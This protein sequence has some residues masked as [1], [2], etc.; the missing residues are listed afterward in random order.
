MCR[1]A[2]HVFGKRAAF[3]VDSVVG[4]LKDILKDSFHCS[5]FFLFL[6]FPFLS[7]FFFFFSSLTLETLFLFFCFWFYN[8]I[9]RLV[10]VVAQYLLLCFGGT[11]FRT[12][13]PEDIPFREPPAAI[14]RGKSAPICCF[15]CFCMLCIKPSR[16]QQWSIS[17]RLC[18]L[19]TKQAMN[20]CGP[21]M[22]PY[23]ETVAAYWRRERWQGFN[24]DEMVQ[25]SLTWRYMC[26]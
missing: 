23:I 26:V 5:L 16:R 21:W 14:D 2:Q 25:L 22:E 19:K 13:F 24:E 4:I 12:R 17:L 10:F 6:S 8:Y 20:L 15:F 11:Y 1:C 9:C 7:F 3:Y 18:C